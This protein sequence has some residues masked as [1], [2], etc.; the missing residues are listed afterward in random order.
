VFLL[1][2]LVL[3]GAGPVSVDALL[4]RRYKSAAFTSAPQP[5]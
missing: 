3:R 2:I 5:R 1:S 4:G